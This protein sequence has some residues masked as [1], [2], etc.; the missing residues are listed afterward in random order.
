MPS[1]VAGVA[2]RAERRVGA[3]LMAVAFGGYGGFLLLPGFPSLVPP[4]LGVVLDR[5]QRRSSSSPLSSSSDPGHPLLL[6]WWRRKEKSTGWLGFAAAVGGFIGGRAR[7]PLGKDTED[8]RRGTARARWLRGVHR[9]VERLGFGCAR[10]QGRKGKRAADR[11]LVAKRRRI[12]AR[13]QVARP[14]AARE[15]NRGERAER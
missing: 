4:S 5:L 10:G 11:L 6:R 2:V 15:R 14:P 8:C 12:R 1:S 3:P 9:A 7:V 13:E